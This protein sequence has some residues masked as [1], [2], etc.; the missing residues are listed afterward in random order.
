MGLG[1]EDTCYLWTVDKMLYFKPSQCYFLDL[2]RF[3]GRFPLF[4]RRNFVS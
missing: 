3:S 1:S 4:L 2:V